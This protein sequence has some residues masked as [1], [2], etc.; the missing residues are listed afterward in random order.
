M[1]A[2]EQKKLNLEVETAD[3]SAEVFIIDGRFTVVARGIGLRN[4]FSLS[5]GIYTVK[6]RVGFESREEHVV[7][8]NKSEK[9]QF[10]RIHFPSPAPLADTGKTHEYHIDAAASES[11]RVHVN[12]G[13]GSSIFVFVRDWTPQEKS[14]ARGKPNSKP[15]RG[16]KLLDAQGKVLV[17]LERESLSDKKGDPWAACNVQLNPGI[18][19]LALELASGDLIEQ[20]IV[21]SKGWQTQVFLLQRSYG[22]NCSDCR[23]DLL[24]AS[25][26][27]SKSGFNPDDP[28]KRLVE[29]A[30]LGLV[31]TRQVL[32][33]DAINRILNGKFENP[34][35]GI[36]GAHL[37][38]ADKQIKL[39]V[40]SIVVAN[41]RR[42]LGENQH[43]DVEALAHRLGTS[44]TSYIFEHPPMLRRSWWQI[45]EATIDKQGL[46]PLNSMAARCA[47][48]IWG[49]EPWLQWMT[50]AQLK[51]EHSVFDVAMAFEPGIGRE[52]INLHLRQL[53]LQGGNAFELALEEPPARPEG[54]AK[55]LVVKKKRSLRGG[56]GE[57]EAK[58][59]SISLD[60]PTPKARKRKPKT[61][62]NKSDLRMMVKSSG[63]PRANVQVLF[64]RYEQY[65]AAS[66]AETPLDIKVKGE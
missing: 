3:E 10:S 11:K 19:R 20:T 62:L 5:P 1:K 29:A 53:D 26:L 60:V 16:L 24:G 4:T 35:L 57:K 34:M 49:E 65:K 2:S 44:K 45:V 33:G 64:D 48:R 50:P 38:L 18:Y 30:R 39:D 54:M 7:L 51:P 9:V 22:E 46:V 31:N 36:F 52:A 17:D 27:L 56:K 21:A 55:N 59:K 32:P 6:V 23:A 13:S 28:H 14:A 41:L 63:L 61:R 12:K 15:Q 37:L 58:T 25:I 8:L 47:E 43:P 66:E 40:L 42:L